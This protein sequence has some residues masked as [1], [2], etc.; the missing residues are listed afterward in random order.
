MRRIDH[1]PGPLENADVPDAVGAVAASRP[2]QHVAGL[3]LGAGEVAAHGGVVLGL[4]GARDGFVQG[5]ADGVL[6]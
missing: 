4:G 6:G 2:E 5:L 3:G 1:I